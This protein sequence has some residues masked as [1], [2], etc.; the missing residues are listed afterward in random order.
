[1]SPRLPREQLAG[2]CWLPRFSDKTRMLLAG[3]LPLSYRLALGSPLGVDGYFLKHFAL[4][5][6]DL[7]RA[8]RAAKDDDALAT[9]FLAQPAVKEAGIAAWN[10][11]APKLGAKGHPGYVTFQLVKFPLYPSLRGRRVNS[12]FEGIELDETAPSAE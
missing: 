11:L 9:W 10:D 3:E 2:C 5:R 4:M 12:I 7:I 1:M 6:G 8:V